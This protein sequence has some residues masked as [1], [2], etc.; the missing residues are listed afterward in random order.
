[1]PG[2]CCVPA[3]CCSAGT[4]HWKG[5]AA[6][7]PISRTDLPFATATRSLVQTWSRDTHHRKSSGMPPAHHHRSAN[8]II[9]ARQNSH[10]G[11]STIIRGSVLF[12]NFQNGRFSP[13]TLLLGSI[14]S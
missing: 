8:L 5:A 14:A 13:Q 9:S 4:R 3:L 12:L 2:V 6:A 7:A 10:F 11:L 1:M